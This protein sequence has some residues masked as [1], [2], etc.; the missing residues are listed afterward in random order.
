MDPDTSEEAVYKH[1][2]ALKVSFASFRGCKSSQKLSR[3]FRERG[4]SFRGAILL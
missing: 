2:W 1:T 3:I 4:F